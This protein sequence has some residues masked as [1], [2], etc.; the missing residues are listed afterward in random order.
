[1]TE[2]TDSDTTIIDAT[3]VSLGGTG[4]GEEALNALL[5][6]MQTILE[7]HGFD[8]TADWSDTNNPVAGYPAEMERFSHAAL[9]VLHARSSL[10]AIEAGNASDAAFNAIRAQNY[11][12]LAKVHLATQKKAEDE[13]LQSRRTAIRLSDENLLER[14]TAALQELRDRGRTEALIPRYM[15]FEESVNLGPKRY[16]SAGLVPKSKVDAMRRYLQKHGLIKK[17]N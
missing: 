5:D 10:E 13:G 9:A 8:N 16:A 6:E 3:A 7:A 4:E 11:R 12:I 1:M 17:K 2:P 14:R 15:A